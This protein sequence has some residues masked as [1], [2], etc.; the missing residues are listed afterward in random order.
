[1]GQNMKHKKLLSILIL[2]VVFVPVLAVATSGLDIK[3]R[4][5]EWDVPTPNSRPH[6]PAVGPDGS[7]WY[8][9]MNSNTLGRLDAKT[10]K[11]KKYRVKIPDS[12]P[13]GLVADKE[14]NI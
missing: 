3:I 2:I 7:L 5:N 6:D 8:T 1:M 13:H 11:I 9:G 4:I 14:G 12:G 10:G